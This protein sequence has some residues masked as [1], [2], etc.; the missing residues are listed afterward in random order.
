MEC[1]ACHKLQSTKYTHSYIYDIKLCGRCTPGNN[2]RSISHLLLDAIY[3]QIFA[4]LPNDPWLLKHDQEAWIIKC[5]AATLATTQ[6]LLQNHS[7]PGRPLIPALKSQDFHKMWP[8]IDLSHPN[9]LNQALAPD[10]LSQTMVRLIQ[11][12]SVARPHVTYVYYLHEYLH[13][14]LT[15]PDL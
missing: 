13:S 5:Y 11:D 9:C 15:D 8:N 6:W 3:T 14:L 4:L 7:T 1:A 2:V 10:F 12:N